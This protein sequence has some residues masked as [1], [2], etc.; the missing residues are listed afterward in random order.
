MK[1]LRVQ[2]VP[3]GCTKCIECRKQ[4]AREWQIRLHEEI[5]TATN[6]KFITLTFSN[7]S[8]Q[9]LINY[10]KTYTDKS[11]GAIYKQKLNTLKGYNLD[12]EIATVATRLFLER[13][14]KKYKT[15][16]RH[17]L[18]TELGHNGTENIHIHGIIW[19]N[20]PLEK[21]ENIWQ[22][23]YMWKGKMINGKRINYVNNKTVNYIVKYVNKVDEKH[24]YYKSKILTS[25]GIG[26]NY[27]N[28][29]NSKLN[30]FQDKKTSEVYT[31]ETGYKISLAIYWRNKIYNEEQREKL[32][33]NRLDKQERWICGEKVCIKNGEEDYYKILQHYRKINNQLGYGNDEKDWNK[34]EYENERRTLMQIA[35]IKEIR[36]KAA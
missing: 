34:L 24:K 9:K 10:E 30:K 1:D 19:T 21:V 15:S 11:T 23:G 36:K 35:R 8:I 2:Y 25:S 6:G 13:W 12:N 22:Y 17:W 7:K 33:L 27:T 29:Y 4:K 3:I 20:E 32:W 5:K 16:L 18:V 14:R 31:L 28:T 26:H